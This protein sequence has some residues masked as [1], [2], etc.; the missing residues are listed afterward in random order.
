MKKVLLFTALI[1]CSVQFLKAQQKQIEHQHP[2][3]EIGIGAG[4]AYEF[5]HREW[6]P[7]FH[8]HYFRTISPHS[9]WALGGG[10]EYLKSDEKHVE[11][12]LGARYQPIENLH[13]TLLPGV[14][15]T[16]KVRFSVHV[17]AIYEVVHIDRFHLGP[18]FGYAWSHAHSHCS[19]GIHLAVSF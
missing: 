11:I 9:H 15:M 10:V 4:A 2:R 14:T 5:N 6:L 19:V 1:A 17:E 12:A 3:N 18:V 16:D 7:S 13:L 8:F